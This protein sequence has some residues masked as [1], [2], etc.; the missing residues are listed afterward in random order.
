MPSNLHPYPL[1]GN[2]RPAFV[3][4]IWERNGPCELGPN[5]LMVPPGCLISCNE[6]TLLSET[7]HCLKQAHGACPQSL[8]ENAGKPHLTPFLN[9]MSPLSSH[10]GCQFLL[11]QALDTQCPDTPLSAAFAVGHACLTQAPMVCP[12]SPDRGKRG[13]QGRAYRGDG[14]KTRV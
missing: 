2:P 1:L 5:V 7:H 6:Q 8:L 13:G 11:R 14:E 3:P 10:K 4:A 9:L 12:Q